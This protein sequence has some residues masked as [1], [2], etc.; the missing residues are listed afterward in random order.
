MHMIRGS[1]AVDKFAL[2]KCVIFIVEA[3]VIRVLVSVFEIVYVV[4]KIRPTTCVLCP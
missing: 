4:F 2:Y 3:K 1:L